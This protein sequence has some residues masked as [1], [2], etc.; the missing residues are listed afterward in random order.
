MNDRKRTKGFKG[1]YKRDESV[2][3]QSMF[4]E[5][6]LLSQEAFEF[7]WSLFADEQNTFPK[8]TKRNETREARR[9]GF[10][11]RPSTLL[12]GQNRPEWID[13]LGSM[14][15]LLSITCFYHRIP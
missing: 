6:I 15:Q 14:Y 8:S 9:N 3:E 10:F 1:Q 7:C 2:T 13:T 5:Y 12:K 11:R 4:V